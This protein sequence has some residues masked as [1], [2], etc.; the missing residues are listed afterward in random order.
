MIGNA[1][2]PLSSKDWEGSVRATT[3][4]GLLD[5]SQRLLVPRSTHVPGAASPRT[6]LSCYVWAVRESRR[7]LRERYGK[8][9]S[10]GPFSTKC[11]MTTLMTTLITS[12]SDLTAN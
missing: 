4:E 8:N 5:I 6:A 12:R 2:N 3:F 1:T 11:S 7:R 9:F 10:S